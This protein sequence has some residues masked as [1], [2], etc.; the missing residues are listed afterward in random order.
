MPTA[1]DPLLDAAHALLAA[2]GERAL[3]ARRLAGAIGASTKVIYSR[4]GGMKGVRRGLHTRGFA[5]LHAQMEQ[6]MRGTRGG[7]R[8]RAAVVAYRAFAASEPA[9]FGLMYGD[10]ASR[11]LPE[12]ADREAA[13][14]TLDL[15]A[16]AFSATDPYAEARLF[17][18]QMHGVTALEV[19]GWLDAG[20]AHAFLIQVT[21]RF[22]VSA[23][24]AI[25]S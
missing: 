15:L 14:P 12:R 22:G 21:E 6:A 3:T 2:E 19:S 1:P 7:A 18:S 11:D 23:G 20:E 17:W 13:A 16:T 25:S 8:L 10:A 9:L 4:H 24:K 5:L